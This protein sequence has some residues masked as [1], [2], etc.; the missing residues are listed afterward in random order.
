[1]RAFFVGVGE[2]FDETQSNTS[3]LVAPDSTAA[4]AAQWLLLDCGF[5]SAAAFFRHRPSPAPDMLGAIWLSHLHGDHFAGLPYLFTRLHEEGHAMPITCIGQRCLKEKVH[6]IMEVAYPGILGKLRFAIRFL[7]LAEPEI[8]VFWTSF[9]LQAAQSEHSTPN[10][11]LRL[12]DG[13]HTLFYSGDGAPTPETIRL[14]HGVDLMIQEAYSLENSVP[15]H[16]SIPAALEMA[17]TA[18]AKRVALVHVHREVRR[19]KRQAI[20]ALLAGH[21]GG[22][23]SLPEEGTVVQL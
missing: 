11:A 20:D 14:A 10:F 5:T 18:E 4:P 16:G 9:T 1:M 3:I 7:E 8:P 15:D 17:Q 12:D 21:P 22:T 23:A 6:E 19:H 13:R 2:A